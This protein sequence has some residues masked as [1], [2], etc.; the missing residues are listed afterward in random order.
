MI[1]LF[2][3]FTLLILEEFFFRHLL[4]NLTEHCMKFILLHDY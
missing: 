4:Q 2:K 3:N 1:T